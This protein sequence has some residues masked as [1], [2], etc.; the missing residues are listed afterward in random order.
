MSFSPLTILSAAA[1]MLATLAPAAAQSRHAEVI[2]PRIIAG[3]AAQGGG[4]IGAHVQL[5][6]DPLGGQHAAYYDATYGQLRYARRGGEGRDWTVQVIDTDG[7][8]GRFS[9]LAIGAPQEVHA[10]GMLQTGSRTVQ[11][12]TGTLPTA[13]LVGGRLRVMPAGAPLEVTAVDAEQNLIELAEPYAGATN[14]NAL[15]FIEYYQ[16]AIAYQARREGEGRRLRVARPELDA[17]WLVEEL[18]FGSGGSFIHTGFESTIAI[19]AMG[20]IHVAWQDRTTSEA[21][22]GDLRYGWFDGFGWQR[23]QSLAPDSVTGPMRLLADRNNRVHL[24]YRTTRDEL[25]ALARGP[26]GGWSRQVLEVTDRAGSG[27][28]AVYFPAGDRLFLTSRQRLSWGGADSGVLLT[29]GDPTPQGGRIWSSTLISPADA[30]WGERTALAH[31]PTTG[32]LAVAFHDAEMGRLLMTRLDSNEEW[33]EPAV[34]DAGPAAGAYTSAGFEADGQRL[35]VAYYDSAVGGLKLAT[36]DG[37]SSPTLSFIDG[38]K[39]GTWSAIGLSS[40]QVI[41]AYHSESEGTLRLARWPRGGQPAE[42]SDVLI[43][44]SSA[45]VGEYVSLAV[46]PL[47]NIYLAYYD[48]INTAVRLAVWDGVEW[49]IRTVA[50]HEPGRN[51]GRY[52]QLA[53]NPE[54]TDLALAFHDADEQRS[55]CLV[56]PLAGVDEPIHDLHFFEAPVVLNS[57][58]GRFLAL[59][60]GPENELHL[61]CFDDNLQGPR[62][63]RLSGSELVSEEVESSTM[64]PAGWFLTMAIDPASGKPALAYHDIGRAALRYAERGAEGWV[65]S[66]LDEIGETGLYPAMAFDPALKQQYIVYYDQSAGAS[67]L[68]SRPVGGSWRLPV[69]LA[70]GTRGVRPALRIADDGHLLIS[71]YHQRAGDLLLHETV[72]PPIVTSAGPHWRRYR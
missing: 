6:L 62:Y 51:V 54:G 53:I 58:T 64:N 28:D 23:E 66:N 42:G 46:D 43:D 24:F 47:D 3:D 71:A 14:G 45:D 40:T 65:V 61:A 63:M 2:P 56:A 31:G 19:D 11:V 22:T 26:E 8:T 12:T 70:E 17:R 59:A 38:F 27:L 1:L 9:S 41:V 67:R 37:V 18:D 25:V 44:A 69:V 52:I 4:D 49:H 5:R 16:P 34:V 20:T 10:R 21:T 57:G 48:R 30:G 7:D 35:Q 39:V 55:R 29:R 72:G 60:W 68:L 33:T 15:F 36:L 32:T 13:N 50:G